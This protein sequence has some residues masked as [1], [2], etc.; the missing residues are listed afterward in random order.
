MEEVNKQK[1]EKKFTLYILDIIGAKVISIFVLF[2]LF[3]P[4]IVFDEFFFHPALDKVIGQSKCKKVNKFKWIK[5]V[6]PLLG[7]LK[8]KKNLKN[9]L[10]HITAKNKRYALLASYWTELSDEKVL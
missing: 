3:K 2:L 9:Y 7:S 5:Q 6:W 10:F 4:I 1:R 8:F